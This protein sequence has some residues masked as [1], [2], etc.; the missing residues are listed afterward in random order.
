[1]AQGYT[2][3]SDISEKA[4]IFLVF[5][6]LVRTA[7]V[8]IEESFHVIKIESVVTAFADAIGFEGPNLTPESYRIRMDVKQMSH[9]AYV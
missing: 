1:M 8:F 7:A 2:E 6:R 9:L 5:C 4:A 3:L